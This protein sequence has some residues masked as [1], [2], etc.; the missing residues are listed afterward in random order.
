M[1]M[2]AHVL[3]AGA[4]S[5]ALLVPLLAS[6][7]GGIV[8][9][10][11]NCGFEELITLIQRVIDFIIVTG[12]SVAALLFAWAGWLYMSARGDTGQIGKA[13]NVFTTVFWGYVIILSAWL[14]VRTIL[15]ALLKSGF[16][17]LG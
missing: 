11:N 6:A 5:V 4:V 17:F 12:T 13:H 8:P 7:Q 9:C 10:T 3:A 16:S 14:V 15:D 1:N 2:Y